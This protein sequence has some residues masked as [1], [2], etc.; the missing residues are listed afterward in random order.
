MSSAL[1]R[2]PVDQSCLV[3]LLRLARAEGARVWIR[4][5][6]ASMHPVIPHDSDILVETAGDRAYAVGEVVLA[7]G[8]HGTLVAHRIVRVSSTEVGLRGDHCIRTDVPVP[9]CQV[10]GT[11]VA[12]RDKSGIRPVS[13]RAPRSV[14][15]FF[16]RWYAHARR[17]LLHA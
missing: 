3:E 10:L 1:R 4:A 13:A 8:A 6:G 14:H 7:V 5:R 9:L 2:I 11:V 16:S 17:E 12:V 15:H